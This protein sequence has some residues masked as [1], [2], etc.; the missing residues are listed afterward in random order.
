M[1]QPAWWWDVE[2]DHKCEPFVYEL[3]KYGVPGGLRFGRDGDEYATWLVELLNDF[4]ARS[5]H[6]QVRLPEDVIAL[7]REWHAVWGLHD[8][9]PTDQCRDMARQII[10]AILHSLDGTLLTRGGT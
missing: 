7:A 8:D 4:E 5:L 9:A 1:I 6:L 2:Y 3:Y 10:A